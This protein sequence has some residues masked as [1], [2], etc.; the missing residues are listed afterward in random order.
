LYQSGSTA[1]SC[2]NCAMK[3]NRWRNNCR[4]AIARFLQGALA[5]T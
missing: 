1:G 4:R 2:D 5:S 3:A